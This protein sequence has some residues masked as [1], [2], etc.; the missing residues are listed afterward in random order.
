MNIE[1]AVT[2]GQTYLPKRASFSS[3]SGHAHI[4][5]GTP[6]QGGLLYILSMVST[7]LSLH[8]PREQQLFIKGT[9]PDA[10]LLQDNGEKIKIEDAKKIVEHVALSPQ[11]GNHFILIENIE[12]MTDEAANMLL[13]TLEE[14]SSR[15]YFLCTT[16]NIHEVL[17]TLIS[18]MSVHSLPIHTYSREQLASIIEQW[19]LPWQP[20]N[21]SSLLPEGE[22]VLYSILEE[23]KE[24]S[25]NSM[26]DFL[27]R[28]Q[29]VHVDLVAANIDFYK[30]SSLLSFLYDKKELNTRNT[31]LFFYTFESH[32][33][34]LVVQCIE[35]GNYA[36][37][38]HLRR[39]QKGLMQ[40]KS[41]I[42]S[43]VH[44]KLAT[45]HFIL[46]FVL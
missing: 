29:S 17:P 7:H 46:S 11:S 44:K 16:E 40:L 38:E 25:R 9:H 30:A 32:L 39:L 37:L 10:L 31:E 35:A 2:F 42:R 6:F 33:S 5:S 21:L 18:R 28:L 23:Y 24:K 13:K 36:Y 20:E 41:D 1:L 3:S 14:P 4:W 12:R 15:T 19:E 26:Y 43:N 27:F 8:F 22:G 34:K 45:H